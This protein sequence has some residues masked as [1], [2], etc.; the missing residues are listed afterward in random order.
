MLRSSRARGPW[1]LLHPK[2]EPH[3]KRAVE[4]SAR[5]YGIRIYRFAN[6]G[7]HM[8]LLVMTRSRS[9]FQG[10]LREISGG[11]AA[12]VT[13]ARK[14]HPIGSPG[15]RFWDFLAYTR[16]VSWGRDIRNL[17]LYFI[18]NLFEAAGL[19]TRRAKEAGLKVIPLARWGP[20]R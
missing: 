9:A 19:L 12:L 3:V 4:E 18:K 20:V 15:E 1:S 8:H 14:A 7:N 6:V 5:K 13:G 10:F 16:I 11:I 17:E 2:N